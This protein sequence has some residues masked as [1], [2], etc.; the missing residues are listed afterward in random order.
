MERKEENV[1]KDELHDSV[2]EVEE[3]DGSVHVEGQDLEHAHAG[4]DAEET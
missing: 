3:A 4:E 1:A 2:L